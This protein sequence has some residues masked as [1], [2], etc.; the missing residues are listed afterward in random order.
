MVTID[1]LFGED[2]LNYIK[3][4]QAKGKTLEDIGKEHNKTKEAIRSKVKREK[5]KLNKG[6]VT[7]STNNTTV[8]D[9]IEKP[10]NLNKKNTNSSNNVNIAKIE[11]KLDFIINLI[12]NYKEKERTVQALQIDVQHKN[13]Y[14]KTSMR[15]EKDVWKEFLEFAKSKN[16]DYKQQDL[17][18]LALREFLE[19]YK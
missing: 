17:I 16:K 19:K 7:K 8:T 3:E 5:Q 15:V 10:I 13:I 18:S 4:Q 14:V 1:T 9:K 11:N 12:E 2:F 6:I